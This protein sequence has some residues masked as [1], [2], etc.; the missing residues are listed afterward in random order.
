MEILNPFFTYLGENWI[1]VVALAVS[2][3]GFYIEHLRA[4][5]PS[6]RRVG[7]VRVT[8]N[9]F[10]LGESALAI[11]LLSRN[12]GSRSGVLQNAAVILA[13]PRDAVVLVAHLVMLDRVL[14]I[15]EQL[16]PAEMEPFSGFELSKS[17]AT[18]TRILMRPREQNFNWELGDYKGTVMIRTSAKNKWVKGPEF[19]FNVDADDIAELQSIQ[20]VPQPDGR[21]HVNWKTRDKFVDEVQAQ[22]AELDKLL[23]TREAWR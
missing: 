11:D 8:K 2:A 14:N 7:R 16:P 17:E 19:S 9:P 10:A 15:G 13:G 1:A 5:R 12:R 22:F 3:L 4:F 20:A 18:I 23:L 21:L 6:F